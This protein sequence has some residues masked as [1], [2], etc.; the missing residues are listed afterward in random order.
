MTMSRATRLAIALTAVIAIVGATLVA[1]AGSASAATPKTGKY[2]YH[3]VFSHKTSMDHVSATI[4]FDV[5][6]VG[7]KLK[8]KNFQWVGYS[9]GTLSVSKA[10]TVNNRGKFSF[11]GL[12]SSAGTAKVKIKVKGKFKKPTKAIVDVADVDPGYSCG[13]IQNAAVKHQN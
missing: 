5:A 6:K 3:K 1:G 10:L 8:V 7:T 2:R 4:T 12:A 13:D 11:E 9:C